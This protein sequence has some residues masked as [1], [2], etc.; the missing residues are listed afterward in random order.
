[1]NG[2]GRRQ[3]GL[4]LALW[5]LLLGFSTTLYAHTGLQA[6]NPADEAVVNSS[7]EQI[8]L[9]F[10]AAVALVRFGITDA[11]ERQVKLEFTPGSAQATEYHQPVPALPAGAYKVS[12]AV[13]GADGHTVTGDFAFTVDPSA[14]A[15]AGSHHADEGHAHH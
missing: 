9:T 1:M 7:P 8:H 2:I 15:H 10:T 5:I 14:T 12:W 11:E 13:I 3:Y 6:S 4:G